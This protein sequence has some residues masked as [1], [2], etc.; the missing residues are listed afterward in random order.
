MTTYPMVFADWDGR[1]VETPAAPMQEPLFDAPTKFDP[2]AP[3][4]GPLGMPSYSC[5]VV[6]RSVVVDELRDWMRARGWQA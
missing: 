5:M 1:G 4:P 6:W 2:F 3:I